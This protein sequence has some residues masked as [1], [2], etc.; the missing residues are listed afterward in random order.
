MMPQ[1]L[2]PDVAELARGKAGT[3]IGRLTGLLA[4]V[5]GLPLAYD[6][7][8]QEDKPPVFAARR[9]VAGALAALAVLVARARV[10]PRA[11]RGR[12]RRPAAA[13]DRRRRGARRAKACR[14]ATRTSRSPRTVR[15]G[16]VRAARRAAPRLGRRRRGGRG[17]EGAVVVKLPLPV[18]LAGRDLLRISD[19]VAG[20]GRGDP[21]P[22]RRAEGRPRSR[23]CPG[24]TLGLFFAQP[25]TRTRISFS[26]AMAQLGGTPITLRRD[27]MQLSRG[28]S[29]ER[30][31]AGALALPRRAR[32][33][34]ARARRARG[35]GGGGDD[36]GD[37]RAH[38]RR[39]PVPGARRRA[40]DPRAARQRSTASA[41]RGSATARTCSSRSPRSRRSSACRSSPRARR[42]TSRRR[43]TRRRSCAT[44]ARRPRA[45][46]SLVTDIWVSLGQEATRAQ[47]LRDLEPYRLDDALLALARAG[48]RSSC[49]ACRRTRARR[50]R[51]RCS[52]APQLGGLG[53]GREPPA[54]AEGAAR[55]AARLRVFS[56]DRLEAVE[57]GTL[58]LI[59][60]GVLLA[61]VAAA[62]LAGRAGVPVLVVFLGLGD[63]ARERRAGRDRVRGRPPRKDGRD[64][65]AGGD[66]VRGRHHHAMARDPAV[67]VPAAALEHRRRRRRRRSP[68]SRRTRSSRSRGRRRSSSAPSSR[69]RT[70]QPCSRR[71]G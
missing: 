66:P 10:R 16:H 36:P 32:D 51:P 44:R 58:I 15:D 39:A 49:T 7:D 23:A 71:C 65:R 9:D 29:L 41:S 64:H 69:R 60:G 42:A 35:V 31:G 6:R 38:R 19:L 55:A 2:N 22:R 70:R 13:R 4:T 3:A 26:V 61:A 25:S 12:M 37:Q 28:E 5:K 63:A 62:T 53:R 40:D 67:A 20:R 54:R 27:E 45:P 18:V 68:R 8:L 48:A 43:D 24:R 50:S 11:A 30:H 52:T 17:G 14:S 57:P 21:R 59:V 1:K 33:P 47:R 34:H 46:T 56:T